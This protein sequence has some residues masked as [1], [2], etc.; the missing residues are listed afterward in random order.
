MRVTGK[1]LQVI[2]GI[3]ITAISIHSNLAIADYDVM[4]TNN[5][6]YYVQIGVEAQA[7]GQTS[8]GYCDTLQIKSGRNKTASCPSTAQNWK[9]RFLVE[10][11]KGTQYDQD[12]VLNVEARCENLHGIGQLKWSSGRTIQNPNNG[13]WHDKWVVR[14]KGR[15]NITIPNNYCG[16]V[17]R[18]NNNL[19]SP[20]TRWVDSTQERSQVSDT[21][22]CMGIQS[23]NA[24]SEA[25]TDRNRGSFDKRIKKR[26]VPP[27]T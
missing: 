12:C 25:S 26:G 16:D 5:S 20:Q 22:S 7:V 17:F 14:D 1:I 10:G 9:R 3:L 8:F 21:L 2:S 19:W 4:V 11:E 27:K 15:Y 23:G 6:P 13:G 18:G 24:A